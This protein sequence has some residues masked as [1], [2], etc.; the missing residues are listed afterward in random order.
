VAGGTVTIFGERDGLPPRPIS[1]IY[2]DAT[3]RLWL[4]SPGGGLMRVDHP[5]EAR[6]AFVKFTTAQGLSSNDVTVLAGDA[7]GHVYAG[8]SHGLD[9]IDPGT[10]RVRHFS[11]ADG[12]MIARTLVDALD[13]PRDAATRFVVSFQL[14]S[15]PYG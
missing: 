14:P 3:G 12:L 10:S 7:S 11:T 9:R 2:C 1:D 8:G 13:I 15:I 6:P 5:G 4:A